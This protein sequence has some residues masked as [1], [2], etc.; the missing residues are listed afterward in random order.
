MLNRLRLKPQLWFS[1]LPIPRKL[2]AIMMLTTGTAIL[3][4]STAFAVFDTYY[5]KKAI[6]NKLS[7]LAHV[8]GRNSVA[9]LLFQDQETAIQ[10]LQGLE[11]ERHIVDAC[12]Y[13]RTGNIIAIYKKPG[14]S[15]PIPVEVPQHEI[16]SSEPHYSTYMSP[17]VLEGDQIGAVFIR[18]SSKELADHRRTFTLVTMMVLALSL[19]IAL[20]IAS[21]LQR[22]ISKPILHLVDTAKEVSNQKN[23]EIRAHAETGDE[24]GILNQEFNSMLAEIQYRDHQLRQANEEL[25]SRIQA[26]TMEL[27]AAQEELIRKEK[28]AILGQLMATISHELRNPLGVIRNCLFILQTMLKSPNDEVVQAMARLERNIHRCDRIIEEQLEFVR[29]G[30][31]KRK[32]TSID[33]WLNEVIDD[34]DIPNTITVERELRSNCDYEIDVERLRRCLI[35]LITNAIHALDTPESGEAVRIITLSSEIQNR[36]LVIRIA[37]TGPGIPPENLNKIFE[38]LFSTK[39]FGVGL[40]LPTVKQIV[41]EHQGEISVE[42]PPAPQTGVCFLLKFPLPQSR[43]TMD[44]AGELS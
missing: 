29:G 26:R 17:I 36:Q 37:D 31:I 4:L 18:S 30:N 21:R 28:L 32:L 35:N 19:C 6:E 25:E 11:I 24:I 41:E 40:G 8:I 33:P 13:D 16:F 1:N 27:R 34:L 5:I 7:I 23:Y 38:P 3:L 42:T 20:A 22:F 10:I 14:Y 2:M 12:I 15:L 44:C 39:S 43:S 9:A